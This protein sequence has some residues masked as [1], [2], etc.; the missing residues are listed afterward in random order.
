MDGSREGF[1]RMGK[2][3][4]CLNT[5]RKEAEEREVNYTADRGVTQRKW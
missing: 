5:D 3:V 4:M 2:T 1:L